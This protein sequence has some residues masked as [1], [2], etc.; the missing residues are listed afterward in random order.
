MRA[1]RTADLTDRPKIE[2]ETQQVKVGTIDLHDRLQGAVGRGLRRLDI[3]CAAS[4]GSGS[5]CA[6]H[7]R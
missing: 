6:S 5:Y 7:P 1:Y 4:A 3:S 2:T